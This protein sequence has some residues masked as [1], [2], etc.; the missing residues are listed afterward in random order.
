M[1]VKEL[2]SEMECT[3]EQSERSSEIQIRS[4]QQVEGLQTRLASCE[5][6]REVALRNVRELEIEFNDRI[7]NKSNAMRKQHEEECR[8]LRQQV[9]E[10]SLARSKLETEFRQMQRQLAREHERHEESKN[11]KVSNIFMS[12]LQ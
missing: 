8:L 9:D 3:R 4:Q 10:Q 6:E 5:A 1:R 11:S 2:E 12:L 7:V